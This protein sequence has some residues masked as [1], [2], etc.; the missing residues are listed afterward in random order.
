MSNRL[1]QGIIHQMHDAVDRVIGV[2]DDSGV[3][4]ACSELSKIG[5]LRSH[6]KEEM[7][8]TSDTMVVDGYTYQPIGNGA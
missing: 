4:I 1:F 3:V 2:I 7:V 5:E 8:Y 6:A